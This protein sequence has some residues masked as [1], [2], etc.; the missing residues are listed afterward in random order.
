MRRTPAQVR[1]D[2][3][4]K[5]FE[6]NLKAAQPL[7]MATSSTFWTICHENKKP[8]DPVDGFQYRNRHIDEWLEPEYI[9]IISSLENPEQQV[10]L[11][12]RDREEVRILGKK[13]NGK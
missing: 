6:L 12:P 5:K 9:S 10:Y 4:N 11:S 3:L 13:A 2:I 7:D 8:L 1:V